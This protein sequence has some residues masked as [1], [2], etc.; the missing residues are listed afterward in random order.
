MSRPRIYPP[1]KEPPNRVRQAESR[2]A[3]AERGGRAIQVRLEREEVQ[4]LERLRAA[5]GFE[6]D[7]DAVA[8]AVLQA[9]RRAR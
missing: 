1:G 7:R 9:A 3:L 6:T 8:F 4:A 2:R 5:H